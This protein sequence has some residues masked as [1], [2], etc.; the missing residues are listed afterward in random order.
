MATL[1]ICGIDCYYG[2]VKVLENVSF[3]I[4]AGELV[5]LLGPNGSGKTT[6][7]KTIS[8]VLKPRV[9]V[10]YL[11]DVDIYE[12]GGKEVAKNVAVVSQD[13]SMDFDLTALDIVLMGRHPYMSRLRMED[14]EDLAV[15]RRAMELTNTWHLAERHIGELSG[16]ERQRVMI[17]RALAQEPKVLLLDEPTT[18]LD[19]NHQL[20]IMDLLKKLCIEEKLVV[21]AVFHDFNLASRYSDYLILLNKGKIVSMGRADDVLTSENIREIFQ[22]D[23]LVRKHHVT[24]ALYVIPISPRREKA[25]RDGR[26]HVHLISGAGTGA[27]LMKILVEKGF[28]VTA[29][30]LHLLDT[31][32]EMAAMLGITIVSEAPFCPISEQNHRVNLEMISRANAVI[33]TSMPIGYGNLLNLK[34]ALTAVEAEIPTFIINDIPIAQRD[35]TGGEAQKLLSELGRRGAIFVDNKNELLKLLNELETKINR[36]MLIT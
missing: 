34:A 28:I 29:G 17:A 11:N 19:I 10:V 22:V 27:Q 9:G 2:S 3:S 1:R 35:F 23:A 31:D 4:S 12:M 6:L 21:L 7:L 30:V 15:A 24:G 14:E 36:E 18:H 16:G 25:T 13:T 32:H 5:G 8:R 20:E 26:L 33:V